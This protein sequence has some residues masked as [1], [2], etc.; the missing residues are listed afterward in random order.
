MILANSSITA[1][2]SSKTARVLDRI[3]PSADELRAEAFRSAAEHRKEATLAAPFERTAV[4]AAVA[5]KFGLA[6]DVVEASLFADLKSETAAIKFKDISVVHLLQHYNLAL[7]QAVLLSRN[8]RPCH[9]SQRTAGAVS[10]VAASNQISPADL[11]NGE[12]ASGHLY[13]AS[14]WPDESL[15]RNE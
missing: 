8:A 10:A 12:I 2:N 1:R 5:A 4:V 9:D 6:A 3:R 13:L 15:F 14:R 11:R 7:A